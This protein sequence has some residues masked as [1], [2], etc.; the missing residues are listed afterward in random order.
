MVNCP[1]EVLTDFPRSFVL[2][3]ARITK[4]IVAL[5]CLSASQHVLAGTLLVYGDSISAAYGMNEEQ[6]W[7][8]LLADRLAIDH[9]HYKV[10]NASVSGE[11]TGGGVTRLPKTLE[12]HQ[13]D[14][15]VLELGGN[16]GLRG[17]PISKIRENLHIMIL[18][19][20]ATG[21]RVLLIGM[22]LPPNYGRRY[23]LA[24][25]EIFSS[26]AQEHSVPLVPFLLDGISTGRE[27]VQRDGIHPTVEAQPKLLED[28][29]PYLVPIL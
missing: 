6:G 13:P 17:Y 8:S 29:W 16:D 4:I 24:F 15:L 10:I 1:S 9:P 25:E 11:T 28:V 2:I 19:A 20:Q 3:I 14:I 12:I 27:L 7:V 21:A 26:L 18:Q 23:T 5:Y 22:V